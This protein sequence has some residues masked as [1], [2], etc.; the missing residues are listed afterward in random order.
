MTVAA[1]VA[2]VATTLAPGW[3]G[4]E[5]TADSIARLV[6]M[7]DRAVDGLVARQVADAMGGVVVGGTE[8]AS[9]RPL[10]MLVDIGQG[11]TRALPS[12]ASPYFAV[13]PDGTMVAYWRS[14]ATEEG[15]AMGELVA[16]DLASGSATSLSPPQVLAGGG[17]VVWPLPS[18]LVYVAAR[19]Q[20]DGKIGVLWRLDVGSGRSYC[21]LT[22]A[23]GAGV[24]RVWPGP[25]A[26]KTLYTCG[27]Q[28]LAV[29]VTGATADAIGADQVL[30]RQPGG[31]AWLKLGPLVE[32][33]NDTGVAAS[34]GLRATDAAWA[35]GGAAIMLA[36]GPKLCVAPADLSFVRELKGFAGETHE[37]VVPVWREGVAEGIAGDLAGRPSVHLFALGT[38]TV[39]VTLHFN[40][41]QALRVGTRTWIATSFRHL[42]DG[43]LKPNWP[44]LKG[45]FVVRSV[46]KVADGVTVEAEN[47]G[48]QGGE[49]ERLRDPKAKAPEPSQIT[50]T[51][52]GRR[53]VWVQRFEIAARRDARAWIYQLPALGELRKIKVERRRLDAP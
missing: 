43:T 39:A 22:A 30:R 32:L 24:G 23:A 9:G 50:T 45:C 33:H 48:T 28:S 4:V 53:V 38:E 6:V 40:M 18:N 11:G 51:V 2:M 12:P 35:P 1:T 34:L 17:S 10:I 47:Q 25:T 42:A 31:K 52:A 5:L 21:L 8:A 27:A 7:D 41:K 3:A 46:Q 19:P 49:L 37:F 26:D 29:P 13:S 15:A 16:A 36:A 44:S 14:V 20:G